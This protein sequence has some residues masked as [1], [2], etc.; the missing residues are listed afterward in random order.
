MVPWNESQGGITSIALGALHIMRPAKLFA[1]FY[2]DPTGAVVARAPGRVNLIGEHTDYNDGLVLPMIIDR[3]IDVIARKRPDRQVRMA[4]AD[5]GETVAAALGEGVDFDGPAWLP[6]VFGLVRTFDQRGLLESGLDIVF[7]GT[8]PPSAGLASSAALEIATA[9][10]VEGAFKLWL[11]PVQTARLCQEVEHRF[12]GVG[13]GLMDQM[14]SRLGRSGC[15]LYLDCRTLEA[16][17][18]PL[19]FENHLL[20][21]VNSGAQRALAETAYNERRRECEEAVAILRRGDPSIRS[22]R[23]VP[24]EL[25]EEQQ[26]RLPEPLMRRCRHV[27]TENQRVADACAALAAADIAELGRLMS[28]SH[29]SLRDDYEVSSPELDRLVAAGAA[30]RGVAGARLTG[31][32][33]GGATVHLMKTSTWGA[34]E[35]ALAPVT[36]DLPGAEIFAVR[37]GDRAGVVEVIP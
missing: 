34:F 32:G 28:D 18:V 31:A 12:G 6:Y 16:R 1:Q 30:V 26:V 23:D 21:V 15:A 37:S 24:P 27:L 35:E 7:R 36:E 33:F 17:H 19:P 3:H 13:C 29:A 2:G 4:A 20:A 9:L 14:A 25:L 8:I 5:T 11:E 10:A 22:L